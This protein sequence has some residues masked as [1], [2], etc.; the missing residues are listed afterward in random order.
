MAPRMTERLFVSYS[1]HDASLVAPVVRLLRSTNDFVFLDSDSIK[2]GHRWAG[3]IAEAIEGASLVVVFWCL[4]SSESPQVESE[5]RSAVQA[6]KDVLPVLLDS[7]PVP[8]VLSEFQWIDF[9]EL[10]REK[11]G[12]LGVVAP[13]AAAFGHRGVWRS[14]LAA[15]AAVLLV[16]MALSVMTLRHPATLDKSAPPAVSERP[17]PG[18]LPPAPEALPSSRYTVTTVGIVGVLLAVIA[19][20]AIRRRRAK[21][22]STA[23]GQT[24]TRQDEAMA[25]TL[26][27]ELRRRL[28]RIQGP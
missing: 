24:T 1:H 14:A 25:R 9:R 16:L 6:Q 8:P 4:H 11:H 28:V 3:A 15:S 10:G 19:L 18:P 20:T 7:T 21:V 2:P 13:S 17:S 26:E 5:Y 12:A 23:D 22:R 27:E